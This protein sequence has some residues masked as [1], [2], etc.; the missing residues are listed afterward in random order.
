MAQTILFTGCNAT[1]TR[2]GGRSFSSVISFFVG[3]ICCCIFF[4]IDVGAVHTPLP[5]GQRL[6]EGKVT[7]GVVRAEVKLF[8]FF[9]LG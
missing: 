9:L 4:G 6:A 7:L 5:V 3:S 8:F 2:Y 1:L